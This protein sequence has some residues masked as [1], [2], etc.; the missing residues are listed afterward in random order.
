MS[1]EK[2]LE[3]E[4]NLALIQLVKKG[5]TEALD[6]LLNIYIPQLNSFFHYI[7]YT[8]LFRLISFLIWNKIQLIFC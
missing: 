5:D 3:Q 4:N 8:L 6:K 7:H 2:A 1:S